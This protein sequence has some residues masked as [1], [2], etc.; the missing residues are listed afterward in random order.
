MH[1]VVDNILS[2]SHVSGSK[3]VSHTQ[4]VDI[5][6]VVMGGLTLGVATQY[7]L[8]KTSQMVEQLLSA[9]EAVDFFEAQDQHADGVNA[10]CSKPPSLPHHRWV[11][12]QTCHV[13]LNH[14]VSNTS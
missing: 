7:I 12:I 2:F 3:S 4:L 14:R 1:G 10:I 11:N 9:A 5:L 13:N 6:T 8:T